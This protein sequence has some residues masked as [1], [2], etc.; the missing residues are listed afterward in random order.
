M[1]IENEKQKIGRFIKTGLL[2]LSAILIVSA[3]STLVES[4]SAA[5]SSRKLRKLP[6]YCVDTD[7][8]KIS[9]SFDAAWGNDSLRN[10]SF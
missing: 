3:G 4:I 7:E 5:A 10:L 9:L 1:E 2:V 8:K 6:I